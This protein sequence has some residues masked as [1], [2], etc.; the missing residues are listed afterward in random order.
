MTSTVTPGMA[1]SESTA[2]T[3]ALPS[4]ARYTAQFAAQLRICCRTIGSVKMYGNS[5]AVNSTPGD[6][7]TAAARACTGDVCGASGEMGANAMAPTPTNATPVVNHGLIEVSMPIPLIEST[8]AR[9][10]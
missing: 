8:R 6:A 1:S 2:P 3:P 5:N 4:P 9:S 10:H 7:A